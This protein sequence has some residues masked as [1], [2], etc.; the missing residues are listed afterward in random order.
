MAHHYG[1]GVGVAISAGW[2]TALGH[3]EP[4]CGVL[5]AFL[6]EYAAVAY[7]YPTPS[8]LELVG[9]S[10]DGV[11]VATAIGV[12]ASGDVVVGAG[13]FLGTYDT[14]V[15]GDVEAVV[16]HEEVVVAV[17][18]NDLGAFA[19]LPAGGGG[20]G[21]DVDAIGLVHGVG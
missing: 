19:C 1:V 21:A 16:G 8:F 9:V 17:V 4:I 2:E 10:D 5:F 6:G 12:V 7:A 14:G 20:A 15:V 18:V 3:V 13:D 11:A